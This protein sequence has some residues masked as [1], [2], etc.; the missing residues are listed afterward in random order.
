MLKVSM[1]N[2]K[3]SRIYMCIFHRIYSIY[4]CLKYK[5]DVIGKKKRKKRSFNGKQ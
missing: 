4:A 3:V 1:Q 5:I 2:I